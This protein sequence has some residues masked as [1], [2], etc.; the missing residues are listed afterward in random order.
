M[1]IVVKKYGGT[2]VGSAERI[3]TVAQQIIKARKK[4]PE[5]VVI[6]S[7]M[8]GETDRLIAL[9]HE[10]CQM[11]DNREMDVL[12]STG[13][14]VS[15]ALL[16]MALIEMG[17]PT[18]SLNASQI[19][20]L[21]DK[22]HTKAK[23]CKINTDRIMKELNKGKVVIIAG[24]QG[25]TEDEDITTLGRG[26]SDTTAVAI[27]GALQADVC[28]IFTDVDGV[29]TADPRIVPEAKKLD[30]ISYEEMLEM[31]S[32]GAKVLHPRSV[33]LAKKFGVKIHVLSSFVDMH[34]TIVTEEVADMEEL[35]ISGV[36]ANA[37]E[38][39]ITVMDIPD[40]PGMAGKLFS[41]LADAN[42]NIDM[43]VQS[44]TRGKTNDI[45]FTVDETDL[46]KV[47]EVVKESVREIGAGEISYD[48]DIAKVSIV[49]V[50]MKSHSG[51]A[52]RMFKA[53]AEHNINIE[54][55][56][57]SEIKISCI[58]RISMMEEAVR[59]LHKAFF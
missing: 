54:M 15:S 38:A 55:I 9:G 23:I 44:E 39:K 28:E 22:S 8:S 7:A 50:G 3:K 30:I 17:C 2:S 51:V 13:E 25:I 5:I 19:E 45:S 53:L 29:Y 31:A 21:T 58:I 1:G 12:V 52:S 59:V 10:I 48:R 33:E 11:P 40:K 32:L 57:T 27:A 20:I 18:I 42:I 47:I 37:K 36:T 34:G 35:L 46:Q 6:V 4:E 26:G 41:A 24:F 14:Q 43:I 56:S 16:S 49:G